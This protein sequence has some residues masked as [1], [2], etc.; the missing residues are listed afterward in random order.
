MIWH[1]DFHLLADSL[2]FVLWQSQLL[3]YKLRYEETHETRNWGYLDHC[4]EETEALSLAT[5]EELNPANSHMNL[6]EDLFHLEPQR[7]GPGRCLLHLQ[8][9]ERP[10]SREPR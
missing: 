5:C 3:C 10:H 7:P 9:H 6:E 2:P 8:P 1:C 4:Q